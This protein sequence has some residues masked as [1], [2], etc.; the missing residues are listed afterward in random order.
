MPPTAAP[1][2]A[3]LQAMTQLG[4]RARAASRQEARH[5]RAQF[6][7]I[8]EGTCTCGNVRPSPIP[9]PRP[10]PR[11][12]PFSS[13]AFLACRSSF[14]LASLRQGRAAASSISEA[15]GRSYTTPMPHLS[16]SAAL[17]ASAAPQRASSD[18]WAGNTLLGHSAY[19]PARWPRPPSDGGVHDQ[20]LVARLLR[21]ALRL[22]GATS[23]P[24][25][26]AR[27]RRA[28]SGSGPAPGIEAYAKQHWVGR[29]HTVGNCCDRPHLQA[30][31][32]VS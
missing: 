1:Q 12:S 24:M 27:W 7:S 3:A 19:T 5:Q 26:T 32:H 30:A 15:G 25:N 13:C 10:R 8:S 2:S 14:S 17:A 11:P 18:G 28:V 31:Q 20:R 21:I 29:A 6:K 4:S 16:A 9:T 23:L 22:Q